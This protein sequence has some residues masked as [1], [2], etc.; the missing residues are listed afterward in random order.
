L[1]NEGLV[2]YII[3]QQEIGGVEYQDLIQVGRIAL[4]QSLLH[5]DPRRGN[6]FSSYAWAA[7][8]RQVWRCLAYANH[9]L[10]YVEQQG[11]WWDGD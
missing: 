4:W 7:I 8:H 3:Q 6:T 9:S 10:A 5:F 2:H 11:N 1:S